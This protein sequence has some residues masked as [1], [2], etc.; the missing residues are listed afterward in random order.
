MPRNKLVI[1]H[2]L[3]HVLENISKEETGHATKGFCLFIATKCPVF[4]ILLAT[5]ITAKGISDPAVTAGQLNL[6]EDQR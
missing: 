1:V 4:E 6:C 3:I 2:E 5:N